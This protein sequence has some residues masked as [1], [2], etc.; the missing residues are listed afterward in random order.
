M[1]EHP[2]AKLART[3]WQA[4][5]HGDTETLARVCTPDVV[6]HASGHGPRSGDYRGLEAVLDYLA[7]I[8]ESAER[9]DSRFDDVLV[10]EAR[11]AVLFHVTGRRGSKRL[12]TGYILLFRV[13]QGQIAEVWSICRDQHA[14]DEFWS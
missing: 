11:V 5:S 3:A 13:E 9:F 7:A 8:G 6:W 1:I 12:D 2:H 10:G 4:A 14:V